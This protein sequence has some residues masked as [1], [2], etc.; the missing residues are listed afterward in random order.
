[1]K[2]SVLLFSLLVASFFTYV[3]AQPY[4]LRG[5][6][7]PCGWAG[8]FTATCQL[9]DPDG[10]G[11]FELA[12]PY[13]GAIGYQEFKIYDQATDSWYPGDNS[14]YDHKGGSVTYRFNAASKAVDAIDGLNPLCAPGEWVSPNWTNTTPMT[15][16]TGNTWCVTVATP[17]T[18]RWKPTRC[19]QWGSFQQ[20][21]GTR[22]TNSGNWVMT[23]T[24]P[25]QQVCV[26]YDPAT[27]RVVGTTP[28]PT[29]YYVRGSA[30]PCDW[31]GN[32]TGTCQLTDPDGDGIFELVVNYG[33][34]PIGLHEFKIY[35]AA[36]NSWYPSGANAWFRHTGGTVKFRYSALTNDVWVIDNFEENICAPGSFSNWNNAFPMTKYDNGVFCTN[37][38]T[39]GTY[40]WKPT[41]CGNWN[42]WQPV[43]GERSTGAD[44][45][46]ITTTIA[47]QQVCVTNDKSTGR[48]NAGATNIPTMTQW[49]MFLFG[50]MVMIF[51]VVTVRQRKLAVAGQAGSFSMKSLPTFDR[52]DYIRTATVVLSL[53]ILGFSA[54]VTFLGYEV[55]TA[56][57]PGTLLSIPLIA[58]LVSLVKEEQ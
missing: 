23:T 51:G 30:A 1:M 15:N 39:P 53:F 41:Y 17:G 43:G 55:T 34:N 35:H 49:G 21:D 52:A 10:N 13:A 40:E 8:N 14:W 32:F 7:A 31:F 38:P 20:F 16:V 45:W 57:V 22:S 25:N 36:T 6:A 47:N 29:G 56:D 9:T 54:A 33:A 11:I 3:Q 44:N 26:N 2:K 12:V 24:V 46:R 37:I 58:Y 28:P 42:S 5:G 19:G 27:G 48:L 4:Y 50:I 18:Y